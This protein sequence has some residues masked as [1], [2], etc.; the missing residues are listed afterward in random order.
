MNPTSI[1]TQI[2]RST[3]VESIH[4]SVAVAIPSDG[5]PL[6]FGT[7]DPGTFLR[8][9]AKPFQTLALFRG[10]VVDHHGFTDEE[11]AVATAS[12]GG[13]GEH[14]RHVEGLLRRGGFTRRDLQCGIHP[15]FTAAERRHLI[16]E[17]TSPDELCNNCS[18]KHAGMLLHSA[19]LGADP[20]R[21]LEPDHPVQRSI[22]ST[23]ELFL[24]VDL[25]TAT[26]GIDGCGAPT[27]RVPIAAIARAFSR[28]ADPKFLRENELTDAANR[29]HESLRTAP[30]LVSGQDRF[31][32]R[33]SRYLLP[34][35]FSKDGAEGVY[36][37]WGKG[38]ALAIKSL[39]G[40]DR[41]IQYAV[42][43]LLERLGWL[44]AATHRRWLDAEPRLVRNVAGRKVGK[45]EVQLPEPTYL[46]S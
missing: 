13:E 25:S 27:W 36:V 40:F 28:L 15:P 14:R 37:V 43:A 35:H 17:G 11:I 42:P 34:D 24:G 29:L 39:D 33:W 38:G 30:L 4:Q 46:D 7:E 32:Y 31:P 1:E 10:G 23:L 2:G 19:R 5:A 26:L 21:Y 16:A 8:S 9:V 45:I 3:R 6:L 22:A 12:H 41:G 44:D 20:G 18:G